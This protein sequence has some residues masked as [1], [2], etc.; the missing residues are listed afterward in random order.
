MTKSKKPKT[1]NHEIPLT[2]VEISLVFKMDYKDILGV[3]LWSLLLDIDMMNT[4]PN[5]QLLD[6]PL[7]EEIRNIVQENVS[8]VINTYLAYKPERFPDPIDQYRWILDSEEEI[9][10]MLGQGI[11][12]PFDTVVDENGEVTMVGEPLK[13]FQNT[14][15]QQRFSK[16]FEGLVKVG[17]IHKFNRDLV[18]MRIEEDDEDEE[19]D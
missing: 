13:H 1:N 9:R 7:M 16:L 4:H 5:Y 11:D 2:P 15:I 12:V 18:A 10:T 3:D 19:E 14:R 8:N 6:N 17:E